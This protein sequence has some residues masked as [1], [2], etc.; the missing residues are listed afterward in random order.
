MIVIDPETKETIVKLKK[1]GNTNSKI[2]EKTGVSLPTI[3]KI[4]KE[5]AQKSALLQ[6]YFIG[7]PSSKEEES[8]IF[9]QGKTSHPQISDIQPRSNEA[10]Q[11]PR[12]EDEILILNLTRNY[13]FGTN[14]TR[15]ILRN[16][17]PTWLVHKLLGKLYPADIVSKIIFGLNRIG[18]E[19]KVYQV[20]ISPIHN[21]VS[22]NPITQ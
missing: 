14:T 16:G 6:P 19:R 15:Q 7:T 13:P 8:P 17:V 22:I 10:I 4:L 1:E 20:R 12:E 9:G 3:R 2:R 18:P 21:N 11:D 5:S